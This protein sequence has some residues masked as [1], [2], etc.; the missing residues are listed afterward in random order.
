MLSI[1]RE[2]SPKPSFHTPFLN[3]RGVSFPD[4][5]LSMALNTSA[6][7]LLLALTRY[8]NLSKIPVVSQTAE[9]DGISPPL[10]ERREIRDLL[11]AADTLPENLR[12]EFRL[13]SREV[14]VRPV[15]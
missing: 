11:L 5:S 7:S 12:E 8:F 10:G 15:N 2:L 3:S 13:P 6:T 14:A 9:V 1:S 4:L